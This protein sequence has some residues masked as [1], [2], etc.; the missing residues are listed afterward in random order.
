[1]SQVG[2]EVKVTMGGKGGHGNKKH[3]SVKLINHGALGA[4]K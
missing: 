2:K 1:M 4:T 3:P